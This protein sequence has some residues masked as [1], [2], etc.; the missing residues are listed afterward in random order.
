MGWTQQG[1]HRT[2]QAVAVA[3]NDGWLSVRLGGRFAEG[4]CWNWWLGWICGLCRRRALTW[5]E[6]SAD[7]RRLRQGNTAR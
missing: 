4:L 6:L 3:A 7:G 1:Q 2:A 5:F